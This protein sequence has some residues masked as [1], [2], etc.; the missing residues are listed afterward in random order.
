MS[1]EKKRIEIR[2]PVKECKK[3]WEIEEGDDY[4]ELI[5]IQGQIKFHLENEHKPDELLEIAESVYM[6]FRCR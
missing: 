1:E 3:K 5:Y 2:C 6:E 4:F